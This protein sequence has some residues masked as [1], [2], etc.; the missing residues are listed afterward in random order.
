MRVIAF[1]FFGVLC[2]DL[3][4]EWIDVNQLVSSRSTLRLELVNPADE[5]VKTFEDQ[6]RSLAELIGRNWKSVYEEFL[7]LSKIDSSNIDLIERIIANG[8]GVAICSNSPS[9][10]IDEILRRHSINT[11]WLCKVVSGDV[12]VAKPSPLIFD[13]LSE[14]TGVSF[15]RCFLI[16]DRETNVHAARK[17]G[18]Q[19]FVFRTSTDLAKEL[20]AHGLI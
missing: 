5:G 4:E 10:L 16:D 20:A 11:P 17:V 7:G 12:G 15:D 14:N 18:M 2:S 19:A 9:G 1:D 8:N 3:F 6:C 13:V